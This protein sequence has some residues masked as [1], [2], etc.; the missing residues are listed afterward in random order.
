MKIA[1]EEK[2]ESQTYRPA[3]IQQI[4]EMTFVYPDRVVLFVPNLCGGETRITIYKS[5]NPDGNQENMMRLAKINLDT[6]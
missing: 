5:S 4:L 6:K 1:I 2:D 3:P